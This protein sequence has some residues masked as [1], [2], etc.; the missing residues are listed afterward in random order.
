MAEISSKYWD[1]TTSGWV[2]LSHS[3]KDYNEVKIVRDYLEEHSFNAL[4]FYL[5]CLDYDPTGDETQKLI[6]REIDARNIFVLCN[7][8]HAQSSDWVKDE[9]SYVKKSSNKIYTE[10]NID[11]MKQRKCTELSILD[12]LINSSTLYLIYGSKDKEIATNI[13]EFLSLEGFKV[14]IGNQIQ[15]TYINESMAEIK[16][17]SMIILFINTNTLESQWYRTLLEY[18]NSNQINVI[19]IYIGQKIIEKYP[20]EIIGNKGLYIYSK[21]DLDKVKYNL[22]DIIKDRASRSINDKKNIRE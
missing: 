7:S 3:S 6:Y 13:S 10:L 8:Q 19:N 1:I 21:H 16:K 22:L 15:K 12:D 5:K 14:F 11:N 9:V 18:M 2:F 20:E 17:D 4:M